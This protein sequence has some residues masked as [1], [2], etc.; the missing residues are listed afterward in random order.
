M[1]QNFHFEAAP[2]DVTLLSP[3]KRSS[4]VAPTPPVDTGSA[5]TNQELLGFF[6]PALAV[7]DERQRRRD[8]QLAAT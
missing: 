4:P 8:E 2:V 7:A 1:P 5:R 6:L 3:L